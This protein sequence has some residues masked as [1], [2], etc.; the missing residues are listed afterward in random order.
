MHRADGLPDE[1]REIDRPQDRPEPAAGDGLGVGDALEQLEEMASLG[2]DPRRALGRRMGAEV[3]RE[4]ARGRIDPDE[5]IAQLV[6]D[7]GEVFLAIGR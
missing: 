5:R 3:L 4:D 1:R 7:E 2:S 6:E